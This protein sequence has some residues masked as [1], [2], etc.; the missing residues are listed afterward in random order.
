[1]QPV[2]RAEKTNGRSGL[3]PKVPRL[4]LPV[5]MGQGLP[6]AIGNRE[7]TQ[8]RTI[9]AGLRGTVVGGT[10]H[11]SVVIESQVAGVS[12]AIGAGRQAAG[13]LT[14]GQTAGTMQGQPYIPPGAILIV[15]GPLNL[16]MLHQA[17]NSGIA[18]VIASS[19]S[20]RDLEHFLRVDLID[21]LNCT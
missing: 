15:P 18:G 3:L 2:M 11:G 14:M 19:V 8:D 1:D 17:L 9:A 4:S 16:A 12:G 13:P 20:S 10:P 5:N 7:Q 6:G 21:L